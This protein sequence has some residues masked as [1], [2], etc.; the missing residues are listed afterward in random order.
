MLLDLC[1]FHLFHY[2]HP[3][4]VSYRAACGEDW[5]G[6]NFEIILSDLIIQFLFEV[7]IFWWVSAAIQKCSTSH[8]S[9]Y[10]H[11]HAVTQISL[12]CSHF[13]FSSETR[14]L[15]HRSYPSIDV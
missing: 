12:A 15:T 2:Y 11:P 4:Y 1:I 9:S 5:L 3:V 8:S 7:F 6:S 13:P 14:R 10:V